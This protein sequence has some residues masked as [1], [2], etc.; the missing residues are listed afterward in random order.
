MTE[1]LDRARDLYLRGIR[2]GDVGVVAEHTGDVY[3]QHSGGV[4]DGVEGFT[5]FFEEF[6]RRNP[7]REINLVRSFEDDNGVFVHAHQIL[8]GGDVQW[9]T[10]DWFR[11]DHDNK[12]LE[13]WD[14]IA[15]YV[16]DNPSGRSSVDGSTEIHN[17]AHGP[18]NAELVTSAIRNLW[19]EDGDRQAGLDVVSED[20][21][22]HDPDAEDGRPAL[23]ATVSQKPEPLV[24]Q[25][26]HRVC[27]SGNFV[28]TLSEATVDDKPF[29]IGDLFRIEEDMIAEHWRVSEAIAPQEDWA[30][31]GKF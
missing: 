5:Q 29:A 3:I 22:E 14:V 2:D 11:F 23:A 12:I 25:R 28:A 8:D 19:M 17:G 31:T 4:A 15:P 26:V 6:I 18:A 1:R 21:I 27:A 30:N 16:A 13:H 7:E 20:Y 24:F 9:V 10:M